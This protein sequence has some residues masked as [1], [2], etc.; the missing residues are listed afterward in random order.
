MNFSTV[1]AVWMPTFNHIAQRPGQ[2]VRW[3]SLPRELS[4]DAEEVTVRPRD[5]QD[6]IYVNHSWA[7]WKTFRS[8]HV[9]SRIPT[10]SMI[11]R[12][13]NY[14]FVRRCIQKLM[15]AVRLGSVFLLPFLSFPPLPFI[16]F[17][18]SF[19]PTFCPNL[20]TSYIPP[21]LLSFNKYYGSGTVPDTDGNIVKMK[22]KLYLS[23]Y[24]YA[25]SQATFLNNKKTFLLSWHKNKCIIKNN[26]L[27]NFKKT[28]MEPGI[29]TG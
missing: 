24:I 26:W 28:I 3:R 15:W 11:T 27:W 12:V 23:L 21:S 4:P 29:L 13:P 8:P 9:K 19:L 1:P 22:E 18:P 17:L 25:F 6:G 20:P 5:S 2:P 7:Q 16:S 10:R 14:A